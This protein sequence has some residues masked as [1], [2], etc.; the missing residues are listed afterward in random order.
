MSA[1]DTRTLE[2]YLLGDFRVRVHDRVIGTSAWRR[3]KAQQLFK[4]LL[5]RP[6]RRVLKD[7]AV[8]EFWPDSSPEAASS[9]LRSS[10]HA[11]RQVLGED[12]GEL[13]LADGASIGVRHGPDVWVDADAFEAVVSELRTVA[14]P[15]PLLAQAA[16]LYAGDY[17][18]DDLYEDWT[19]ERR[20]ALRRAWIDVEFRLAAYRERQGDL[21][22]AEA[23]LQ[24]ILQADSCHEGAAQELMRLLL[25][26]GRRPDVLRVFQALHAALRDELGVAPSQRSIELQRQA[27]QEGAAA[28]ARPPAFRCSYPFPRPSELIGR[29][30]ELRRLQ[31]LLER[32][33]TAGQAVLISGAAGSGKSTLSGRLIEIAQE[34]GVLCLAGGSYDAGSLVPLAP[35]QEALTDYVVSASTDRTQSALPAAASEL[36]EVVRELR[37]HLGVAPAADA[38][39]GGRMRLFGAIL[40]FIR[41]AADQSPVLLCLED[42]HA[43]DGATLH[44][45]HY[46]VRQTR[47][48]AVT[49]LATYRDEEVRHGEPLAQFLA[50][51]ARDRLAEPMR[52][53]P[54]GPTDATRLVTTLVGGPVSSH[55]NASLYSASEGNPLF[56]EQLVLAL[57]D[58]GR[59]DDAPD[60]WR[61]AVSSTSSIPPVLRDI[62]E[63]RLAG[64]SESS[65]ATLETA[66]VLG[67]TVDHGTLLALVE[68]R[69]EAEL[70]GDLD[71]AIRARLLRETETGYAFGHALLREGVYWGLSGPRRM[72][73]HARA[74]E[75]LERLAGRNVSSVVTELAYH[76]GLAGRAPGVRTRT[77]RYSLEAGHRAAGL[78]SYREA[79][80]HFVTACDLIGE[81]GDGTELATQLEAL[82]GRARAERELAYWPESLESARQIL[83][84]SSS[85]L[86][87]AEARG[88]I[89]YALLHI[90]DMRGVL[91]ETRSATGELAVASGPDVVAMRMYLRQ[92]IALVRY[93]QGRYR[94]IIELGREL[95]REA[96]ELG[97]PS[98]LMRAHLVSGWG[99]MGQGRVSQALEH[100]QLAV[101]AAERAGDKMQLAI[102]HENLALQNY[103]GGRFAAAHREVER[104]LAIFRESASELR[105]VHSLQHLCRV[106]VAEGELDRPREQ[107]ALALELEVAGQ[108]RWAADSH[109]ILADIGMLRA[110]WS[111]AREHAQ[112]ALSVRRRV[113]DMAGIVESLVALGQVDEWT[114]HWQ[115]ALAT[116][117]EAVVAAEQMDPGPP[118][119]D[120]RRHFGRLL[121]AMGELPR[122]RSQIE[123][124][125]ALAEQIP[126]VLDFAP[127][128]LVAAE[129]ELTVDARRARA[130]A[131]RAL[132]HARPVEHV[133]N[134][135]LVLSEIYRVLDGR[136]LASDHATLAL[137]QA[138]YLRAPR[139]LARAQLAV[140]RLNAD[141]QRHGR[142][143]AA[144]EDA[145]TQAEQAEAP[146]ERATVLHAYAACLEQQPV[147]R[148]RAAE[149]RGEAEALFRRLG[150]AESATYSVPGIR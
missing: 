139:L 70:L 16:E 83:D 107:V 25:E 145:L 13:I 84:R 142:A 79:L 130:L 88:Q 102:A 1:P 132:A 133:L 34:S 111:V 53:A 9:N 58:N 29:D 4:Y 41:S 134:A 110:E 135:H 95:L 98:V 147:S 141:Q 62:V 119:V 76:F 47:R 49:L 136:Q 144:F 43:A 66:A 104:A 69:D 7:M 36:V 71:E 127:A 80:G 92:M 86:E 100:E 106:W 40:A 12:G 2:V 89:A 26:Q 61:Q 94:E 44:L 30:A 15:G 87:R 121:L 113:G 22:G 68:P 46:L 10:V 57:R 55:L 129:L 82:R 122:A 6:N 5:T 78:S 77:L 143:A 150:V 33:R 112:Q 73:L 31:R 137:E 45:L 115:G 146:F 90:G 97:Q 85:A 75:T 114:G 18:P 35:F 59:L 63:Q 50:L 54:L 51:L 118:L 64:L 48:V 116:Y 14:E 109:Q 91:N 32:G 8:D 38:V 123:S 124:A 99:F 149:L 131:E 120:A 81:L 56:I 128:V 117:E 138:S 19:V 96:E 67:Q 125:L 108:E 52:L 72:L 28:H 20:E 17:L 105:A 148:E 60:A 42:L 140:A 37:Q 27:A 126:E 74:G 24:R 23:E 11:I 21:G 101:E 39:P 93:L 65:R 3:K 103:L